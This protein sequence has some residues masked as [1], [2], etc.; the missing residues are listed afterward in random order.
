MSTALAADRLSRMQTFELPPAGFDPRTA[1]ARLLRQHGF[2]RRPD[3]AK[4]PALARLWQRVFARVPDLRMVKAELAVDP[5]MSAHDPRRNLNADFSPSGWGSIIVPTASLGFSPYQPANTVFAE[6]TVPTIFPV[7][8]DVGTPLTVGFWVG[9]DGSD[10][11]FYELLQ[12]GTA[13]TIT[14]NSVSYWAWTE[15]FTSKYKT[16]AA[17]VTNFAIEAGDLV[18]FLVC[19]PEPGQGFVS[20]M[21]YRTQQATSVGV[22]A[23]RSDITSVGSR[24]IWAVEGISADLPD[25]SPMVFSDVTAGTQSHA[26]N[27]LPDGTT[28]S[29]TGSGGNP[30]AQAFIASPTTGL[31]LW[32]GNV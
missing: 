28:T 6:W 14:G 9:L 11:D 23:P 15:W 20:M 24:A 13:A 21:N 26:F 12:A 5:I 17:Q 10:A 8:G 16:P 3:P 29:I 22:P 19:A 18:S 27:L 31:V 4:E 7:A 32:E 25:F 2:P 1:P 30:L